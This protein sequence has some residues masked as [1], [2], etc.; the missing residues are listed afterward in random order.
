[1]LGS[2][3][4][5][6][7]FRDSEDQVGGEDVREWVWGRRLTPQPLASEPPPNVWC[8]EDPPKGL[9]WAGPAFW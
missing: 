2:G 4:S 1:M 7:L 5:S 6:K 9:T 8:L 3:G